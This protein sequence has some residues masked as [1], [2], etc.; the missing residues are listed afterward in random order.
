MSNDGVRKRGAPPNPAT[1]RPVANP[2]DQRVLTLNERILNDIFNIYTDKDVGL[3]KLGKLVGIELPYPRRK[4]T[5]MILGNHSA[6]KSSF[7]NW[8]I[9]ETILKTG[10]A[11]ETQGFA[12]V[13][14]GKKRDTLK[15]P[16]TLQLYPHLKQLQEMQGVLDYLTTEVSTSRSR[17]FNL[18]AFVD[19]PGLVDGD[20]NYPFDV[21]ET[22]LWLGNMADLV[23]VFFDPMGQALCKRTL[24]ILESL[25]SPYSEKIRLYLAK[26]DE[27]GSE[28]DRQKVLMQIVQELC[29]R[30]GLNR[31][32]FDMP[33]IYLPDASGKPS[34]CANQITDVC[35]EIEKVI[36]QTVQNS[37]NNLE[38]DANLVKERVSVSLALD[39]EARKRNFRR[40][41]RRLVFNVLGF[42]LPFLLFT[43]LV[44]AETSAE[45]MRKHIGPGGDLVYHFCK[46]LAILWSAVPKS[47]HLHIVIGIVCLSAACL[48]IPRCFP[49]EKVVA[50]RELTNL[51]L[52]MN[53]LEDN[54]NRKKTMYS[55]Y[56][57]QSV[58]ESDF[59]E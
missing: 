25:W 55:E 56:L 34:R 45:G 41:I 5:V 39:A 37:L 30:P 29:K 38:R 18:V 43:V 51:K 49:T 4:V 19:T 12:F 17:K 1:V 36:E 9:E 35:D 8:Y 40:N 59:I 24:N 47:Y 22:L 14:S 21:N 20:M 13:T 23:F 7:I 50:N 27:A 53:V 54:L 42:I 16:A 10:V 33:T 31:T 32:G 52:A 11:I 57:R 3:V 28:T 26:A 2:M 48:M 15:G 6:G 46:P 44:I 58:A